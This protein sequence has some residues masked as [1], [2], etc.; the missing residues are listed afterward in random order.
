M[1][2]TKQGQY[3]YMNDYNYVKHAQIDKNKM[4][5]NKWKKFVRVIEM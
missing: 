1:G 4:S 3:W 5:L 2:F